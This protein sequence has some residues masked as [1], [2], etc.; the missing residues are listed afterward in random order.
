MV[1][2]TPS[3]ASIDSVDPIADR[4]GDAM[5]VRVTVIAES[6]LVLGDSNLDAVGVA[7]MENHA[8]RPE[9]VIAR[10]EGG[11]GLAR[12]YS[13]TIKTDMLYAATIYERAD[14]RGIIR[15]A[16][17]LAE[18]NE[19]LEQLRASLLVAAI[20]ALALASMVGG[21]ASHM[22]A[23]IL[24][25]LILSARVLTARAIESRSTNLMGDDF[26]TLAQSITEMSKHLDHLMR[27]L[28]RER[29]QFRAVLEGMQEAVIA[30]DSKKRVAMVNESARQLFNFRVDPVGEV[31]ADIC[32]VPSFTH[33]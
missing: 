24:R 11:I 9:C 28:A 10:E 22:I 7:G 14:G 6:G 27:T 8:S 33:P 4:L 18:V 13:N 23:R 19:A 5:S 26:G 17:P 20:L 30:V 2:L 25:Q 15:V 31:L 21:F 12:R 29:D 3:M 32:S 16:M 1:L